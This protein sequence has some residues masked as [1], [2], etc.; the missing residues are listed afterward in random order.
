MCLLFGQFAKIISFPPSSTAGLLTYYAKLQF[1]LMIS[2]PKS[3]Y[4]THSQLYLDLCLTT[5]RSSQ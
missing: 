4:V 3:K 1:S 2:E 5:K